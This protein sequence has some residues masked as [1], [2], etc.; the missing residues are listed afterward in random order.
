MDNQSIE[1]EFNKFLDKMSK[2]DQKLSLQTQKIILREVTKDAIK[3][4]RLATRTTWKRRTGDAAKS[5]KQKVGNSK[6][7]KGMAYLTYG[8]RNKGIPDRRKY[9]AKNYSDAIAPKPATYIGIWQDLGTQRGLK[10]KHVFRQQWEKHRPKIVDNLNKSI[11]E[12]LKLSF[13]N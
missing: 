6:T 8:W 13:K 11:E 5:V 9:S 3:D 12:L 2:F 7:Y 10:G 1:S 4:L